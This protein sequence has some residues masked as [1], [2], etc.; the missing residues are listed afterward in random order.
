[1]RTPVGHLTRNFQIRGSDGDWGGRLLV[2]QTTGEA[3]E[4]LKG[5][6]NLQG[7]E[8][9]NMGQRDTENAGL[10]FKF[11]NDPKTRISSSV[12]GCSFHDSK[13]LHFH[14]DTAYDIYIN[15]NVFYNGVKM[16]VKMING[17]NNTFTDNL[18]VYVQVR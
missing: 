10:D 15:Y 3:G 8:F 6:V 13:G 4:L 7:V 1:M 17:V 12:V 5:S 18:M 9:V 16:L 11:T 2:Y 14:A